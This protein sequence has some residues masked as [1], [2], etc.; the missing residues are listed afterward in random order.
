MTE[1][2][3]A[4]ECTRDQPHIVQAID[5]PSYGIDNIPPLFKFEL[6]CVL[7][8]RLSLLFR[9]CLVD[10]IEERLP[11]ICDAEDEVGT[12]EDVFE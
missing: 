1:L 8:D 5:F 9:T 2:L 4:A 3:R 12:F 7:P 10:W 6:I 11:E